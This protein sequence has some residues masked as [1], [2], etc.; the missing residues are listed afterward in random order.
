MLSYAE[1]HI[2]TMYNSRS[3]GYIFTK[4]IHTLVEEFIF[5]YSNKMLSSYKLSLG[6]CQHCFYK[7]MKV[8]CLRKIPNL[9]FTCVPLLTLLVLMSFDECPSPLKKLPPLA[10]GNISK[11]YTYTITAYIAWTA[12]PVWSYK[13]FEGKLTTSL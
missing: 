13:Y 10:Q 12:W 3:T 11:V 9:I 6:S 8:L 5:S 1:Y 4:M 7:L 2:A